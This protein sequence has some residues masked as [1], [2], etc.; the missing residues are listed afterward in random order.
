MSS[1]S[2]GVP[3]T[4]L[5]SSVFWVED[6]SAVS[7]TNHRARGVCY[8]FLR[9]FPLRRT[10]AGENNRYFVYVF[11]D[12]VAIFLGCIFSVRLT[13]RRR[14]NVGGRLRDKRF[15]RSTS[16]CRYRLTKPTHVYEQERSNDP[17]FGSGGGGGAFEYMNTARFLTK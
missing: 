13:K 7:N 10:T 16:F 6:L 11:G 15:L 9:A 1:F 8:L 12:D 17:F 2:A 3:V 4:L 14:W 5:Y